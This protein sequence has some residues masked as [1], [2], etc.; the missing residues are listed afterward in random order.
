MSY[1]YT[2]SFSKDKKEEKIKVKSLKLVSSKEGGG[3]RILA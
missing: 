1:K 3:S 2:R